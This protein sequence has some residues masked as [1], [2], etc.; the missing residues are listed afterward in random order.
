[1]LVDRQ[2]NRPRI[3]LDRPRQRSEVRHEHGSI[4]GR[5]P[6]AD[7]CDALHGIYR[8]AKL[9]VVDGPPAGRPPV[10]REMTDDLRKLRSDASLIL[11][12]PAEECARTLRT[13]FSREYAGTAIEY[14]VG[15]CEILP[16]YL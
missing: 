1:M 11:V 14:L 4:S 12:Q 15:R 8:E 13:G 9:V 10:M 2:H 6:M 16:A 5:G 3:G 7:K